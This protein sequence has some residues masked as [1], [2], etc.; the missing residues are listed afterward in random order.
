MRAHAK[1][2]MNGLPLLGL[3]GREGRRCLPA[4]QL[5]KKRL[6]PLL[7]LERGKTTKSGADFYIS[8][9]RQIWMQ[10]VIVVVAF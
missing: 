1:R 3:K 7:L 5:R 6:I 4:D 10:S 2:G 9:R 8:C